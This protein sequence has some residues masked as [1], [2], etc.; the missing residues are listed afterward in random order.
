VAYVVG[1]GGVEPEV[2]ELREHLRGRLPDYML[3]QALVVREELPL[4]AN[5]KV[6][7]RALP[8]P[9]TEAEERTY[10]APRTRLEETLAGIWGRVLRVEGAEERRVGVHDNFFEL[11]GHSLLAVQAVMSI[12]QEFHLQLHLR[13]LFAAPT[14]A[15]LA[16]VVRRAERAE[17][18]TALNRDRYRG[19][20]T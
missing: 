2:G 6:D 13:D 18:V 19:G 5:G 9:G 7:R 4:T 11:G 10:E 8:E 20:S 15:A 1:A 12:N 17:P 3:P 16:E 14:V